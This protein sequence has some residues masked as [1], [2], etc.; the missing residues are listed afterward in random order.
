MVHALAALAVIKSDWH[1]SRADLDGLVRPLA[2]PLE[3]PAHKDAVQMLPAPSC[4]VSL[5]APLPVLRVQ[6]GHA[7][8][9]AYARDLHWICLMASAGN[10][11][12]KQSYLESCD[13][14]AQYPVL[15][16]LACFSAN[17]VEAAP[18]QD[19]I[20]PPGANSRCLVLGLTDQHARHNQS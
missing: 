15:G 16:D 3:L 17:A 14:L 13:D 6:S 19:S 9:Q 5:L 12:G 2:L 7:L 4:S 18:M 11:Q 8:G 1:V 10:G 20:T